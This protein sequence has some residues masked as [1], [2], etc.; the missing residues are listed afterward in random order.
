MKHSDSLSI[1]TSVVNAVAVA[2]FL[3]LTFLNRKKRVATWLVCPSLI[4]FSY[5]Y[6]AFVDYDGS[7][8]TIFYKVIVGITMTFFFLVILNEF[9]LFSTIVYIPFLCYFMYV[10]GNNMVESK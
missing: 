3:F 7:S 4:A 6:F 5:Y 2:W 8:G 9:W 10:T 1:S